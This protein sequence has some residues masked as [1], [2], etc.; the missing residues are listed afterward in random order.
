MPEAIAYS[1]EVRMPLNFTTDFAEA[2]AAFRE[3]RKP[4]FRGE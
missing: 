3:K 4:E 2:L 1:N